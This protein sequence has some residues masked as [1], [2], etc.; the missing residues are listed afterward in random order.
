[1]PKTLTVERAAVIAA[2]N[3]WMRRYTANPGDFTRDWEQ[4]FEFLSQQRKGEIPSYGETCT[5]YLE[6]LLGLPP[7]AAEFPPSAPPEAD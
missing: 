7:L 5:A 3:E 2:F 6:S 4:V 1:M